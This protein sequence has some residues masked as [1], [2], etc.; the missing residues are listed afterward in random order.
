MSHLK[1]FLGILNEKTRFHFI[2]TIGDH[3]ENYSISKDL[4]RNAR[5]IFE[6]KISN[7]QF[8]K[9]LFCN[10]E[11]LFFHSVFD[12]DN[13]VENLTQQDVLFAAEPIYIDQYTRVY[14]LNAVS[15]AS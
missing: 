15:D 6:H 5:K 12:R 8:Q 1:P 11:F 2:T 9:F 7:V 13:M 4:T 14:P 3:F 10:A